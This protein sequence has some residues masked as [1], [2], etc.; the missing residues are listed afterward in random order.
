MYRF[1]SWNV[2]GVNDQSKRVIIRK[3]LEYTK[4]DFAAL[5]E[6]KVKKW[7]HANIKMLWQRSMIDWDYL[8]SN[9]AS[10][11]ILVLW[12]SIKFTQQR[13]LKSERMISLDL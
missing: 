3:Y 5:V 2:R 4:L 11:G 1:M 7:E 12:N 10:G 9:G 8:P 13:V 6:T